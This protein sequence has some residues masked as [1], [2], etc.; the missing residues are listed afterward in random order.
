MQHN[1]RGGDQMLKYE[2]DAF[3]RAY[4]DVMAGGP[5]VIVIERDDGHSDEMSVSAYFAPCDTWGPSTRQAIKRARG[6]VLDVGCG[7]GRHLL[8]LQDAGHEVVG[9]DNS[10]IAIDVARKRGAKD[11]R[12]MDL[13]DIGPELGVFDTVVML[14]NNFMLVG[15]PDNARTFLGK[16]DAIT[17][18]DAVIL[19]GLRDPYDTDDPVHFAYHQRNRD[20]GRMA[21]QCRLRIKCGD[22]VGPWMDL[23]LLS[24][25]ELVS[26]L[27]GTAWTAEEFFGD[28]PCYTVAIAKR[29]A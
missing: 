22:A 24:R 18:R 19:A 25:E 16:L 1:A 26:L 14:G 10:P 11:A 4:A 2:E 27:E 12:L 28:G 6:R 5:G 7:P 15:D 17:S 8:Y 9:I 21:G 29:G 13:D 23:L 3:G 20:A